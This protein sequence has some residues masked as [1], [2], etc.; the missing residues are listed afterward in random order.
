MLVPPAR[1]D[2]VRRRLLGWYDAGHR[3]LPWRFPQRAADPYR[4]WLA[5]VMLQQTRVER[6]EGYYRRFLSRWPG[7]RA[8][9]SAR[10]ADVLAV[11]SGLGYYARARHL[12]AAARMALARHGGLPR[13]PEALR[14]LPG[15][16][17][18]TAGAVASMAF[19]VPAPA[20]DGNAARV[21]SRLFLVTGDPAARTT[22]ERLWA[23]AGALV[24][25]AEGGRGPRRPGDFNQ[26][27]ME[28]GATVCRVPAPACGRCPL[29]SV[30]AARRSGREREVPRPRRRPVRRRLAVACAVLERRGRLLLARR[31]APGLF[32]GLWAPPWAEVPPGASPRAALAAAA[33]RAGLRLRVGQRLAAAEATLTH[34]DLSLEAYRCEGPGP[35][36]GPWRWVAWSGL[37]RLGL[38]TATR[39]LLDAVRAG[40]G[41]G[42]RRQVRQGP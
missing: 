42:I 28:L 14:A 25:G 12:L 36:T 13:S 2:A 27:L 23:L 4:V 21:L 38:A 41:T 8:L 31:G 24:P 40:K 39:A 22:G 11:W 5:E 16:G 34:R 32:A 33:R 18:Y 37:P 7:L 29:A 1:R 3:R 30:C 26:A 19:A 6:V 35:R 20:V 15:F 10:E 9:A 17:R